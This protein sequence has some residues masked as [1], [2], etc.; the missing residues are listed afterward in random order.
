MR[1]LTIVGNRPQFIKAAAASSH[2]RERGEEVLVH[3][4]QHYDRELS[5]LFFEELDLPPPDHVLGVGAGTHAEQTARTITRLEPLVAEIDPDAVL[6]YGD[7]NATL[8]GALVA[9]KM[10]VP[11][12]H[13]E[14]GM[15]SFDHSMP[16]EINRVVADH[17]S[18]LLLCSTPTAVH[19]LTREGLGERA[20]LVGDLMADVC[21]T[22]GPVALRR[23]DVTER[24]GLQDGSY[25]LASAHRAENVDDPSRLEKLV[26]VLVAVSRGSADRLSGSS[27]NCGEA[28]WECPR[29][30]ARARPDHDDSG[31]GIPGHDPIASRRP[32]ASHR[33][34]WA[35]KR[36][37][38]QWHSLRHA[39]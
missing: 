17:L 10:Q 4:G 12:V 25:L 1:I 15:R 2:L 8:G 39:A 9:A 34:G 5:D 21:L 3:T 30:D 35:S 20:R 27:P 23:S 28:S 14:A 7:T 26:E 13:V 29:G 19:N 11:L 31:G 38:P 33:L 6:V 37:V 32:C 22:F 18:G 24:L 36:G 16:E